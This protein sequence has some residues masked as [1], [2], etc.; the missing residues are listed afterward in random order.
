MSFAAPV[1]PPSIPQFFSSGSCPAGETKT[2]VNPGSS[3]GDPTFILL[4]CEFAVEDVLNIISFNVITEL[5]DTVYNQAGASD[6]P[7]WWH[8]S[9]FQV[10]PPN[11]YLQLYNQSVGFTISWRASG[12][13]VPTWQLP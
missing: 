11:K 8:W 2:I 7:S 5:G 1:F 4:A 9:T 6:F 12:L 10:V 3:E 13:Q